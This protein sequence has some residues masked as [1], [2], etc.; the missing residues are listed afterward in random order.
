[1]EHLNGPVILSG[2]LMSSVVYWHVFYI[3]DYL[4]RKFTPTLYKRLKQEDEVRKLCPLII[5]IVRMAFG[6]TVSLPACVQAA[7]TT[8]WGVDRPLNTPGQVCI[9]SQVAVWSNELP[10]LRHYSLELFVH[11][12]LCLVSTSNI[13]LSP[14][15]HQIKPFYIYFGSLV[16]DIGPGSVMILRAAGHNLHTS[17]LLWTVSLGSTLILIFCRI[18]GAF[19]TLTHILTDPYN[20]ADWVAAVGTLLFGSY[21]SYTAFLHLARLGI[22]KVDPAQYK[23][24]YLYRFTVPISHSLLAVACSVTLLSTLFLYGIFLGRPLRPGETHQLSLHGLVAVAIGL[25]GALIA[26]LAYPHDAS[27]SNPWGHLYILFGTILTSIWI[28]A[29]STFTDYTDRHTVLA[30][31][32]VSLPLFF[33]IAR[34]AQYYAAK[35]VEAV[36]DAKQPPY[37]S[38]IKRHLETSLEYAVVFII[39]LVLL[40]YNLLSL[41]E[42]ARLS[43][44][45]CLIIQLRHR[46]NIMPLAAANVHGAAGLFLIIVLAVLEPGFVIFAATGR[47]IRLGHSL[48]GTLQSYMLLGGVVMAATFM[49]RS[50]TA[51]KSCSV[52]TKPCRSKKFHPITILFIVFSILQAMLV[53]RYLTFDGEAPD[54]CLGFVNFQ[55]IF[56]DVFTWVGAL[57]MASLPVAVLRG[58]DKKIIDMDKAKEQA[59][60]NYKSLW[61]RYSKLQESTQNSE[62]RQPSTPNWLSS[63]SASR[64]NSFGQQIEEKKPGF[65]LGSITHQKG[66]AKFGEASTIHPG[67]LQ[68]SLFNGQCQQKATFWFGAAMPQKWPEQSSSL[69]GPHQGRQQDLPS[70]PRN[71][72]HKNLQQQNPQAIPPSSTGIR[73][74]SNTNNLSKVRL[75]PRDLKR[76]HSLWKGCMLKR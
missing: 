29:V 48:T 10:Q 26:R 38:F 20:L 66:S 39:L 31:T 75:S 14:P 3:V 46:W 6:M 63:P 64:W 25:T 28:L 11:H 58:L 47:W 12:I 30:S 41:P 8:P 23:V 61:S 5:T 13:I 27:R 54:I 53:R 1:M 19:Y 70:G 60:R 72:Q 55:S 22:V 56:S 37:D 9:V 36:R 62:H 40:T 24:T 7:R 52:V 35:D 45:A 4:L 59:D 43:V 33:A 34:V 68:S 44:S 65:R 42:A 51:S 21:S 73:N 49:P 16:G 32:G 57:H 71:Q 15:I 17:R 76:K 74:V 50:N 67:G 69:F 2:F 18:G